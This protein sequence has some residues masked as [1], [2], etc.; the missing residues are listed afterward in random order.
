M[1]ETV[2]RDGP[3]GGARSRR[4]GLAAGGAGLAAWL[5]LCSLA[6]PIM[7]LAPARAVDLPVPLSL[8]EPTTHG[9]RLVRFIWLRHSGDEALR[10]GL[11][12]LAV[13]LYRR[14]AELLSEEDIR[15]P[16]LETDLSAALIAL[17]R[18]DEAA[19]VLEAY[20]GR[21]NDAVLLRRGILSWEG[22]RWDE[23]RYR[24]AEI[25]PAALGPG[26]AAWYAFLR[27]YLNELEGDLEE[28]ETF[29]RQAEE[30]SVSNSQ[31]AQFTIARLRTGLLGESVDEAFLESVRDEIEARAGTSAVY[32]FAEKYILALEVLERPEEALAAAAEWRSRTPAVERD[33]RDRFLFLEG[34]MAGED[35]DRARAAYEELLVTGGSRRLQRAALYQLGRD[36]PAGEERELFENLLT[37]LIEAEV[38]HPLIDELLIFRSRLSFAQRRFEQGAED[39]ETVLSQYPGSRLRRDALRLLGHIAWEEEKYRTAADYVSRLRDEIPEG[40][41]RTEL[42]VLV[43]DCYFRAEDFENAADAYGNVLRE[44]AADL[45]PGLLLFQRVTAELRAGRLDRAEAHLDETRFR[46]LEDLDF[47]WRAEWNL[48]KEMQRRDRMEDAFSRVSES[49]QGRGGAPLPAALRIRFLWLRAQLAFEWDRPE[50]TLTLLDQV[51]AELEREDAAADLSEELARAIR[52]YARLVRAQAMLAGDRSDEAVAILQELRDENRGAEPA[53]YSYLVE[54]RY[55]AGSGQAVEAQRLLTAL[56][57]IYPDSPYAPIALYEAA[58]D[59]GRGGS[60]DGFEERAIGRL[61]R[62]VEA[63]PDHELAFY[64]RLKQADLLRQINRFGTARQIYESLENRYPDHPDW[65]RVRISLAD[66]FLAQGETADSSFLERALVTLERLYDLP[67]L[68]ADMRA[69]AGFKY[70]FAYEKLGDPER[71]REVYWLV[72]TAVLEDND[73]LGAL[74]SKGRYWA[75]RAVFHLGRLLEDSERW[76]EAR[77]IYSL[78]FSHQLPGESL[79]RSRL[80]PLTAR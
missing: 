33:A 75:S 49:L 44:G 6:A 45:S 74:S 23:L 7:G 80:T 22:Q 30:G 9:D 27:G 68:S 31:R 36:L 17:G 16:A 59:T 35:R 47:V 13:D 15:R 10:T 4:S 25:N 43:A 1:T 28:A 34:L 76:N 62:L 29:Y 79:A 21:I 78:I 41:R 64:A 50:E 56:A 55:R 65:F 42:G 70:G 72:I 52:G 67:H 18:F 20:S 63:Y 73:D 66:T 53:I 32:R 71:A 11:P 14:A 60:D 3:P 5:I 39:A 48:L 37:E 61:E 77:E 38:Q 51:F 2:F 46:T 58:V 24:L 40:A 19:R 26:E 57:D 69:E 8:E 54:A 12:T